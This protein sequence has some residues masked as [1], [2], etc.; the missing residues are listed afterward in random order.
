MVLFIVAAMISTLTSCGNGN[1]QNA[2]GD[3]T[4]A[5]S[6]SITITVQVKGSDGAITDF[7]ITTSATNLRGAL[8]EENLASGEEGPYGLYVKVV[9]GETADYDVDKSYWSFYKGDDY[10]M[11][12]VDD[13]PISDG[14]VFRIEYTKD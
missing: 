14:D 2:D 11:T 1:L 4:L 13:T 9:N 12:G 8:E 10:L 7:V 5:E 3:T 6:E